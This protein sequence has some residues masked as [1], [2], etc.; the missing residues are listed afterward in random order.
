M[1]NSSSTDE[2]SPLHTSDYSKIEGT[3]H[4]KDARDIKTD[5]TVF[6]A[7]GFVA[8]RVLDYLIASTAAHDTNE[9]PEGSSAVVEDD[10]DYEAV[11]L[12][13]KA[14]RPAKTDI[15]QASSIE[16]LRVTLAGRNESKLRHVLE[17][18]TALPTYSS[19]SVQIDIF[20]A[21]SND[22]RALDAMASSTYVVLNCAGPFARHGTNVVG[23]CASNG[24]DYVDITGEVSWA[25]AMR[26]RF[27]HLSAKS[28]SRII[29]FCGTDSVPSDLSVFAAVRALRQSRSKK[30]DESSAD[31]VQIFQAKTWHAAFGLANGGTLHTAL[32]IPI[33]ISSML[34]NNE[35]RKIR[36]VPY[37]MDH[38]FALSHPSV[39][40]DPSYDSWRDAAALTEWKNQLITLDTE[41][42]SEGVTASAPF[43]MAVVNA[44]VVH[45]SA[46]SLKYSSLDQKDDNLN[47]FTYWER[48]VPTGFRFNHYINLCSIIPTLSYSMGLAA[49]TVVLK[50]PFIGSKL[51]EIIMPP[52]RGIPDWINE[53]GYLEVY[54]EVKSH[55]SASSGRSTGLIDKGTCHL[56]F[57]GDPGKSIRVL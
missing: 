28:G 31:P 40:D 10:T 30:T 7:T 33:D 56:K 48:F 18:I 32:N 41:L 21:D 51:A 16:P 54:A 4:I 25:G 37:L 12:V 44:K 39:R 14:D 6:G 47:A 9:G 36:K 19:K 20:V 27:G 15:R 43:F 52:G 57:E 38:P 55:A 34:F 46:I 45:A 42:S 2:A 1:G 8:R 29:S 23:A 13:T 3:K 24:C 50:A 53:R 22:P 5:I 17:Q 35:T 49:F 11:R 26:E